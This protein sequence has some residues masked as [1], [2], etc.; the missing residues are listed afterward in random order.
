MDDEVK[1]ADDVDQDASVTTEA[2]ATIL[3]GASTFETA[4]GA[5][6]ETAVLV[7]VIVTLNA[8][9]SNRLETGSEVFK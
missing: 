8:G 5:E 1:A 7:G 3:G 2:E 6:L 4:L 9:C